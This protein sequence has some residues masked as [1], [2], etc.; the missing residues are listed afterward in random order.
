MVVR[1]QADRVTV[2]RILVT[3]TAQAHKAGRLLAFHHASEPLVLVNAWDAASARIVESC[4]FPALATTSAGVANLEG[5]RD[6]HSIGRETMLAGVARIARA[7]SVPVTA[8]MENGYGS[9]VEDAIA[10]AR[11]VIAAGAVGLNFED[12]ISEGPAPLLDI[13]TQVRRIRAIR[14]TA[15]ELGVPLVINARTD[16]Y[17]KSVG[18]AGARLAAT[19]ERARAYVAAGADCVFVPGVVDEATIGALVRGV[20]APLNVLAGEKSPSL[21]QLQRLGVR[22]V[23]FGSWPFGHAMF[24]LQ[25]FAIAVRDNRESA[26]VAERISHGDL[27]E[28]FG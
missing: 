15:Q 2:R 12:G 21:A 8:D 19:L 26:I 23:S 3:M 5:F 22:R 20:D 7:A 18:D 6:G 1:G 11:G 24:S 28:L 25:R 14:E 4:G 27:N 10:T 16:M 13:P 17:L 9:T